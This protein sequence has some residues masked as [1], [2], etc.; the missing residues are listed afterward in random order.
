MIDQKT[1]K[2]SY[3]ELQQRLAEAE[4]VIRVLRSGEIDAIIGER[5]IALVRLRATEEALRKLTTELEERVRE[6]TVQLEE[7]NTRLARAM[8]ELRAA[9]VR[10]I[11]SERLTTLATLAAAV[12]HEVNNPLMGV[13]NAV[14]YA[15]RR[16]HEDEVREA[17]A[18]ADEGLQRMADI[19]RNLLGFVR[20]A[21]RRT[22]RA[23]VPVVVDRTLGFLGADLQARG[24]AVVVEMASSLPAAAI[25]PGRLQQVLTNLLTNARDAVAGSA[26][27]RLLI[28]AEQADGRVRIE[29]QDSGPGVSAEIRERIFD[30]FFSTKPGQ[31]TGLG[32]PVSRSL[33]EDCGGRLTLES[34]PGEG[35][36]FVV[37][38]P[39]FGEKSEPAREMRAPRKRILVVDD[40][41]QARM[42]FVY[43]LKEM[44]YAVETAASGLEAI[45]KIGREKF[46]LVF[47]DLKMPG[48]DGLETLRR[49][50]VIDKDVRVYIVT[51]YHETFAQRLKEASAHGLGFEVV[52]KPL[53]EER[54][55]QITHGVLKESQ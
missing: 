11:E 4:E 23:E 1:A 35:A 15:R 9:Q 47:L 38:L 26:E 43:A 2:P 32:L 14:S 52:D 20:P 37:A 41:R 46:D 25:D 34:G 36:R 53:N 3:E 12:A 8:D 21:E 33:V 31:G 16:A 5:D 27:K 42:A 17:L 18:D 30:P 55:R 45:E 49:L 6:R 24:V 44:D 28:R 22:V 48:L 29:V 50:R 10:L 7:T 19:V 51:A 13:Q 54:I 40:D 39:V